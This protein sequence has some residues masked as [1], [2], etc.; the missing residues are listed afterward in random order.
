MVKGW[1]VTFE[2]HSATPP[3]WSKQSYS[4]DHI[5]LT[6][7]LSLKSVTSEDSGH[8]TCKGHMDIEQNE[9]FLANAELIVVGTIL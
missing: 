7:V 1:N 5:S 6:H 2:C 9:P 8:Y 4:L 3:Q